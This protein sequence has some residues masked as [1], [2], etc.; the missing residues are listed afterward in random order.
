VIVI[1]AKAFRA[2]T[3]D[4]GDDSAERAEARVELADI[5]QQCTG[6]LVRDHCPDASKRRATRI[7]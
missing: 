4:R 1:T 5:V 7:E 3:G 6:D 2:R